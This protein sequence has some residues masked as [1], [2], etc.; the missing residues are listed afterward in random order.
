MWAVA[1]NAAGL[2]SLTPARGGRVFRKPLPH[3]GP[4][5]GGRSRGAAAGRGGAG[6]GRPYPPRASRGV[7]GFELQRFGGI[8]YNETRVGAAYGY[9]LGRGKRGRPARRAANQ[10]SGPG[11]PPRRGGLAGRAGRYSAPAAHAGRVFIQP[12]PSQTGEL[13]G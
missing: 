2:S 6:G 3:S 12:H 11:Q 8:L 13:P 1:N 5:P 7:V 9:R 10:L 4:Q